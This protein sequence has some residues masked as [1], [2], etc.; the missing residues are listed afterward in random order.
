MGVQVYWENPEQTL[1]CYEFS[2]VWNHE[3]LYQAYACARSMELSVKHR[4]DVMILGLNNHQMITTNKF[5]LKML[6]RR[7]RK[8]VRAGSGLLY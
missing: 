5:I 3:D 7:K 6:L 4:V 8:P 2:G 1:I